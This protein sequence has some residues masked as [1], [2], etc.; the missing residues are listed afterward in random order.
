M[1][2]VYENSFMGDESVG[3]SC[4]DS[5]L[6]CDDLNVAIQSNSQ[7]KKVEVKKNAI[8][9]RRIVVCSFMAIQLIIASVLNAKLME[10][11]VLPLKYD[12]LMVI[13][14]VAFNIFTW[15][16]AKTK[17]LTIVM[18]IMSVLVSTLLFA[19]IVTVSNV[20]KAVDSIISNIDYEVVK[21]SAVVPIESSIDDIKNIGGRAMGYLSYNEHIE[22]LKQEIEKKTSFPPQYTEYESEIQLADA[23]LLGREEIMLV[24]GSAM[25][26]LRQTDGYVDIDGRVRVLHTFEIKIDKTTS[27]ETN[28]AIN[29]DTFVVYISGSDSRQGLKEVTLSDTNLLAV[30]N[31]KRR[32][33]QLINT[34]RDYYVPIADIN[35]ESKLTH[36]GNGGVGR[37]MR[38]LEN[39]YGIE[40][41]YYFKICFE[42][43]TTLIDQLG[44][45]E[46]YS[47]KNFT[48]Y[49]TC[50]DYYEGYQHLN[51]EMALHFARERRAFIDG[52]NQRG[53]NQMEVIKGIGKKM[54]SKDALTNFDGVMGSISGCFETDISSD[55][56]YQVVKNQLDKN[57]NWEISTKSVEGYD[58]KTES[59]ECII[60]PINSSV[61]EAKVLINECLSN[62]R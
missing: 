38:T 62:Q 57:L 27:T 13:A 7:E 12:I 16:A 58:D 15:F 4:I 9:I 56:M 11:D 24:E 53:K 52:D 17:K 26:L 32:K 50:I 42:G 36:A 22:G 51:G 18:S 6:F 34:P 19:G 23:L 14:I 55:V 39:L 41:D 10:V 37:S 60:R 3:V 61:E 21:I 48:T 25:D 49:Y 45:I 30:V 20:D 28:Q 33:I 40:V 47:P 54:T 59:G 46:V 2:F 44:G 35:R 29:K 8:K 43:F 31:T 1:D 5:S